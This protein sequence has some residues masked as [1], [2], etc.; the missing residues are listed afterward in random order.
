[1]VYR[2]AWLQ[3][4]KSFAVKCP[5]ISYHLVGTKKVQQALA[6]AGE[7]ERFVKD[8]EAVKSLQDVFA[9]LWGLEAGNQ[10]GLAMVE[11]AKATPERFVLKPQREGGGNNYFGAELVEQ[12]NTMQPQEL[13]SHILMEKIV[14][15]TFSGTLVRA[16]KSTV[17]ECLSELGIYGIYVGNESQVALNEPAVRVLLILAHPY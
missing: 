11:Q 12:L 16:N 14:P 5:C 2:R 4:E 1:M 9:G 6:K 8:P 7:L 17:G 15:P 10:E 13:A 3:I